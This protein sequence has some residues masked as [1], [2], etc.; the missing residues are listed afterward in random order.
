[1]IRVAQQYRAMAD[2][3][4]SIVLTLDTDDKQAMDVRTHIAREVPGALLRWGLSRNKIDAVNRNAGEYEW[5]AA[6]FAS[7]DMVPVRQ[8]YDRVILEQFEAAGHTD[9]CLWCNDARQFR[10]CTVPVMGRQAFDRL[11][12]CYHPDYASYYADDEWTER[13]QAEGKL[14]QMPGKMFRHDH[15]IFGAARF[16]RL[17]ERN[18]APKQ[19][20]HDTYNRRKAAGYP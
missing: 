3:P 10:I 8:G 15:W 2:G 18:K 14:V 7:D 9:F 17:Y 6:V 5:D 16:D 12:H 4:V 11:G 13:F 20:D 19:A 1:M